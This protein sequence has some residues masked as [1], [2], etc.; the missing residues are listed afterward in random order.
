MLI[1]KV[2]I[3]YLPSRLANDFIHTKTRCVVPVRLPFVIIVE[4]VAEGCHCRS[5]FIVHTKDDHA[6]WVAHVRYHESD[7]AS[8]SL[9]DVLTL[10]HSGDGLSGFARG[11]LAVACHHDSLG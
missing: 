11:D 2:L 9:H 10:G 8:Q 3:E 7:V 6:R 5:A 4:R 1:V